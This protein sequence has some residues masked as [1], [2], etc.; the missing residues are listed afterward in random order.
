MKINL[1]SQMKGHL[2][3][4]I[5]GSYLKFYFKNLLKMIKRLTCQIFSY[6]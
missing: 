2:S 4:D 3:F 6:L 1:M 5:N